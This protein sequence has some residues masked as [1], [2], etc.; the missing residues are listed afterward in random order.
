MTF[1]ATP[2]GAYL[3]AEYL[4]DRGIKKVSSTID[5]QEWITQAENFTLFYAARNGE[6]SSDDVQRECPPPIGSNPNVVGALFRSLLAKKKI[7]FVATRKSNRASGHARRIGV[8]RLV[9]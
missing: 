3:N 4:Q 1:S 9:V 8:Y 6:V 2:M 7:E 5:A